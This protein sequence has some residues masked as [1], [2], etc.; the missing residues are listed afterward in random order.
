VDDRCIVSAIVEGYNTAALE[1][2][3]RK[4]IT[5][6]TFLDRDLALFDEA[7]EHYIPSLHRF[8]DK[9]RIQEFKWLRKRLVAERNQRIHARR[10]RV[11]E[12][13]KKA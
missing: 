5:P 13:G 7:L 9:D 8:N 6:M 3:R 1:D 10:L 2:A 11:E 4:R 12:K